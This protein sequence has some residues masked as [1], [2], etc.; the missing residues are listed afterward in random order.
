[1]RKE[2]I[3]TTTGLAC[4]LEELVALGG[5]QDAKSLSDALQDGYVL[6]MLGDPK[7][8]DVEALHDALQEVPWA[9]A[10]IPCYGGFH[11]FESDY[12]KDVWMSQE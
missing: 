2:F 4:L 10:V 3:S 6:D 8:S 9:C 11:A 12:D 1:M 7:Q 5:E